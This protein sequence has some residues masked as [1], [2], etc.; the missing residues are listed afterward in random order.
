MRPSVSSS[1]LGFLYFIKNVNQSKNVPVYSALSIILVGSSKIVNI[2]ILLR[3]FSWIKE[4]TPPPICAP[5]PP[6]IV[7]KKHQSG[8]LCQ[9]THFGTQFFRP[10]SEHKNQNTIIC[11]LTL[12][13][14]DQS[15]FRYLTV[16]IRFKI[17]VAF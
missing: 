4:A 14:L 10:Y 17:I 16:F 8:R 5:P 6:S 7:R 2:F 15:S 11:F 3:T 1:F 13:S 9:L 12:F